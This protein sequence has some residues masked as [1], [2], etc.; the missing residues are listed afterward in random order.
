MTN[1]PQTLN[2]N[3]IL[4]QLNADDSLEGWPASLK[5]LYTFDPSTSTW[6]PRTPTTHP[7]IDPVP[8]NSLAVATWNVN[9]MP[10]YERSRLRAALDHLQTLISPLAVPCMVLIQ[11][12]HFNCFSA[13]LQHPWVREQYDLTDVSPRTWENF[14]SN[15]GTVTL[16]PRAWAG[17]TVSVFRTKFKGSRMSREALFVD[18]VVPVEDTGALV[19]PEEP[20][21]EPKIIRIANVHLESLRGQGDPAR[22]R[23]LKS[24]AA[25]LSAPKI[26]AGLVGGDMNPIAPTDARLRSDLVFGMPG[27]SAMS[28]CLR[29]KQK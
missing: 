23:Q 3:M 2:S 16:V 7:L 15:Y 25:F 21:P 8:V 24:V 11:E 28:P 18:L 29:R 1:Q 13:L 5:D 20:E 27:L 14:G 17:N 4:P 9:F 22:I 6:V 10:A 12:M 19:Q 26:Y